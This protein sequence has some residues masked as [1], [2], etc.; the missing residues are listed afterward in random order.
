[1]SHPSRIGSRLLLHP[2][3]LRA[4][5]TPP[6]CVGHRSLHQVPC[7]ALPF[8][9]PAR[10][11]TASF[12]G[13]NATMRESDS[14]RPLTP[15]RSGFP[16]RHDAHYDP[17]V[18]GG[19]LLFHPLPWR[20]DVSPCPRKAPLPKQVQQWVLPASPGE[21]LGS[22][23]DINFGVYP[24]TSY[25]SLSMHRT[26]HYC[27]ARK[28]RLPPPCHWLCGLIYLQ[29]GRQTAFRTHTRILHKPI[30]YQ[31]ACT[32]Y[33]AFAGSAKLEVRSQESED[34]FFK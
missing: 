23:D 26:E 14:H 20:L 27:S 4:D 5:D 8:A 7:S 33:K 13:F 3:K 12:A 10:Q 25:S 17:V 31:K 2:A 15:R 21:T 24:H 1:M 9:P 22:F 18:A 34:Y 30:I 11:L 28:T 32:G 29:L 19:S 16:S 6:Q